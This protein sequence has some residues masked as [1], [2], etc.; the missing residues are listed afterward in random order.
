MEQMSLLPAPR[1][2]VVFD[3][4]NLR[5]ELVRRVWGVRRLMAGRMLTPLQRAILSAYAIGIADAFDPKD[6]TR[7]TGKWAV[8][9]L[10]EVALRDLE[11]IQANRPLLDRFR[12]AG[13]EDAVASFKDRDVWHRMPILE[14]WIRSL[15][16][17]SH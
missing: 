6:G 16:Q 13:R 12:A 7:W 3:P 17:R 9:A 14:D 8:Q 2:D 10:G 4:V 15:E 11:F 5:E 1:P